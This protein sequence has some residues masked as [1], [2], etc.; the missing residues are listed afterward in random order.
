MCAASLLTYSFHL[1]MNFNQT[2]TEMLHA[3]C[4]VS[5]VTSGG[6]SIVALGRRPLFNNKLKIIAIN[7]IKSCS[8]SILLLVIL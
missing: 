6:S 7:K 1:D 3:H 5:G 4:K 8:H 2:F